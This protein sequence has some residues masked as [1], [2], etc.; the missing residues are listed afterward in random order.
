MPSSYVENEESTLDII[1][2]IFDNT[3]KEKN[4]LGRKS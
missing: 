2:S 3:L 4:N 1:L